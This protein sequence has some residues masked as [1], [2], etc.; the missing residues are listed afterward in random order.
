MVDAIMHYC[1][2][3]YQTVLLSAAA[4][5]NR[6]AACLHCSVLAYKAAD[7]ADLFFDFRIRRELQKWSRGR[8]QI[9]DLHQPVPP[10]ILHQIWAVLPPVCKS[11]FKA[12]LVYTS[13][14]LQ[15][16]VGA[17]F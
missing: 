17:A 4:I 15:G 12:V 10:R 1:L 16:W 5:S 3:L 2:H 9:C 14:F 8:V 6:L 13:F 11:S 7:F